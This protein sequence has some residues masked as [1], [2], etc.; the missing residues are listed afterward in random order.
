[1]VGAAPS[2]VSSPFSVVGCCWFNGFEGLEI[3]SYFGRGSDSYDGEVCLR[4]PY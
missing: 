3:A 1:M 4:K 2:V